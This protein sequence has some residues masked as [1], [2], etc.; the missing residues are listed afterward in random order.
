MEG[1]QEHLSHLQIHHSRI[2]R[3]SQRGL[4]APHVHAVAVA[5]AQLER[6]L[7][8]LEAAVEAGEATLDLRGIPEDRE[9]RLHQLP[10]EGQG[11]LELRRHTIAY[12]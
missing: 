11:D 10:A 9:V 2:P 3:E 12:Q 6:L 1:Q 5:V 8:M 4:I 7:I